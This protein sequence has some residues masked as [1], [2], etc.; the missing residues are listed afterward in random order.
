MSSQNQYKLPGQILGRNVYGFNGAP[1]YPVH[2]KRT[3]RWQIIGNNNYIAEGNSIFIINQHIFKSGGIY[4]GVCSDQIMYYKVHH[5]LGETAWEGRLPIMA[6]APQYE[7]EY[8]GKL[9]LP[10]TDH[11]VIYYNNVLYIIGGIDQYGNELNTVYSSPLPEEYTTTLGTYNL[12]PLIDYEGN[13]LDWKLEKP[14]PFTISKAKY[15]VVNNALFILGGYSNNKYNHNI[16]RVAFSA[17]TPISYVLAGG[18]PNGIQDINFCVDRSNIFL[19]GDD[20]TSLLSN[21]VYK[22]S[23]NT[24]NVCNYVEYIGNTPRKLRY[25]SIFQLYESIYIGGAFET[26]DALGTYTESLYIMQYT[27]NKLVSWE[28]YENLPPD[29]HLREYA[30]VDNKIYAFGIANS[31][32]QVPPIVE[33]RLVIYMKGDKIFTY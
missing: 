9:P 28:F 16:Y 6:P 27:T 12:L 26:N 5:R 18:I 33:V 10:M 13:L 22:L 30:I 2:T 23:F 7:M 14:L 19:I 31:P 25:Y 15:A 24:D 4:N 20:P 21:P 11:L 32:T 3:L 17:Y 1:S 8:F 29:T